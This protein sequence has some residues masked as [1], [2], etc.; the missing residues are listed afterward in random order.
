MASIDSGRMPPW[1]AGPSRRTYADERRLS[2]EDITM[3]E[4]WVGDGAPEG[5]PTRPI[6]ITPP[7]LEAT[8]TFS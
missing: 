5:E 8:H 6:V 3:F 2:A 7:Q 1:P 4:T